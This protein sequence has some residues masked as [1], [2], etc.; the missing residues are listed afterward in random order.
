M[1]KILSGETFDCRGT[2]DFTSAQ[3]LLIADGALARS[4]LAESSL[5][6]YVI[7]LTGLR[8]WDDLAA[9]LPGTAASDDL[10]IIEGSFGTD[11]P[12]VQTSD[13]KA[14]TVTQYA[15]F[16]F[17]LRDEYLDGQ[18]ITLR[19][20]AGMI[21]TVSDGTATVDAVVYC[22]DEDGAVSADLCTTAATTINSLTKA[23]VDFTITSTSRTAGDLLD[24]R[25]AIAITDSATGTAVIG[26]ISS[27]KVLRDIKG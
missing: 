25:L 24:V 18:N 23:N 11:A 12:T 8:V 21:T 17:A 5:N 27:V 3:S 6:P 1:P 7:E 26:E 4:K 16:I 14:T 22:H 15:R 19:V 10:G 20:R 9:L 2:A 13:A